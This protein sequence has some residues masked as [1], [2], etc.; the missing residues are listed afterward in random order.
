MGRCWNL[1]IIFL[2]SSIEEKYIMKPFQFTLLYSTLLAILLVL[3][4]MCHP[5]KGELYHKLAAGV[6]IVFP[7][8]YGVKVV[9]T[10]KK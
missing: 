5:G 9:I 6:I 10:E 3:V 2:R 8:L 7:I 1:D 4:G